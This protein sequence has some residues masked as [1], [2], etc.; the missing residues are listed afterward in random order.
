MSFVYPELG[1]IYK[2]LFYLYKTFLLSLVVIGA[3]KFSV[4]D[5]SWL[6]YIISIVGLT[7]VFIVLKVIISSGN[8]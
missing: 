4:G 1:K 5:G 7:C 8:K 2:I 3:I 6:N